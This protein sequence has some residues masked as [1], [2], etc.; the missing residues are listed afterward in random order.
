[1]RQDK[2]PKSA[3]NVYS[4]SSLRNILRQDVKGWVS[5]ACQHRWSILL[6]LSV[7]KLVLQVFSV[8]TLLTFGLLCYSSQQVLRV[9]YE[10]MLEKGLAHY[11]PSSLKN[12]LLNRSLLDILCDLWFIPTMSL[13]LKTILAPMISSKRRAPEEAVKYLDPLEPQHRKIFITKGLAFLFPRKLTKLLLP[14]DYFQNPILSNNFAHQKASFLSEDDRDASDADADSTLPMLRDAPEAE[15]P[16]F[17]RRLSFNPSLGAPRLPV[18]PQP[19]GPTSAPNP[20]NVIQVLNIANP[21]AGAT[22][23]KKRVLM[24]SHML[25][26][27]K[28]MPGRIDPSWDNIH[29]YKRRRNLG[30]IPR[31]QSNDKLNLL[32]LLIDL[33]RFDFLQKANKATVIKATAASAAFLLLQL[34]L[35]RKARRWTKTFFLLLAYTSGVALL[36]GSVAWLVVQ[37][38]LFGGQDDRD[39]RSLPP[40]ESDEVHA[41][42][43]RELEA[44]AEAALQA[45]QQRSASE[46]DD[47]ADN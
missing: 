44:E 34:V 43:A 38:K 28:S 27:L 30:T 23:V 10:E 16:D 3:A 8:T 35:F 22:T 7:A 32:K 13:Y 41:L 11:L 18:A 33:K 40:A 21:G 5:F 14:K 29:E 1:M 25:K 15:T 31:S 47:E 17:S 12:A 42:R 4:L 37:Q 26:N 36:V 20:H 2:E 9:K 24:S 6:G 39:R 46:S 45:Q 19:E